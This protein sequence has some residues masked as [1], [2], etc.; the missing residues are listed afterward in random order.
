MFSPKTYDAVLS[1]YKEINV[2]RSEFEAVRT[3]GLLDL[4]SQLGLKLDWIS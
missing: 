3:E 2:G 1:L 4:G